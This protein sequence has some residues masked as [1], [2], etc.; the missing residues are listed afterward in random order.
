MNINVRLGKN[1]TT[2]FNKAVD[3]YGEDFELLNGLHA[4]QLN[5]TTFID[6]FTADNKNVAD[7][8]IDANAN[9]GS[10]DIQSLLKEKGKSHDKLIAFNKIF[11]EL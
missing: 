7:N 9:V 6:N 3:T 5:F 11:Y 1:F 10:K 2:A 4:S 8:T